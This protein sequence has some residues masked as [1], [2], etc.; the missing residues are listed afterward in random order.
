MAR[1]HA[2]EQALLLAVALAVVARL[3]A[4]GLGSEAV[5]LSAAAAVAAAVA[6]VAPATRVPA[7]RLRCGSPPAPPALAALTGRARRR[8]ADSG[9]LFGC[10]SLPCL[11]AAM[12]CCA[13]EP[14]RGAPS[15]PCRLKK[16]VSA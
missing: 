5:A 14:R 4:A 2:V 10:C 7:A 12:A 13:A 1:G 8:H 9:W 11:W 6:L 3:R 15:P 16:E